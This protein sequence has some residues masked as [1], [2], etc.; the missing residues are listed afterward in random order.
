MYVGLFEGAKSD[1]RNGGADEVACADIEGLYKSQNTALFA[2]VKELVNH[3]DTPQSRQVSAGYPAAPIAQPVFA[4]GAGFSSKTAGTWKGGKGTN[5]RVEPQ[6]MYKES[7]FYTIL[8]PL[9]ELARC[10]GTVTQG[11]PG[12]GFAD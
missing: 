10:P 3:P 4:G 1:G 7:P 6:I 2:K 8:S 12:K 11:T 9:S 5:G